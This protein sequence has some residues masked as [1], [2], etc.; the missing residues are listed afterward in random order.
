[1]T[2][3]PDKP[4]ISYE[5]MIEKLRSRNIEIRDEAFARSVLDSTSY[6][7]LIN[8]YK[9]PFSP[10]RQNDSFQPGTT[11][12]EI[13][14][15]HIIDMN[16]SSI[17]L[18]YILHTEFALKSRLSHLIA[19]RYGVISAMNHTFD[20]INRNPDDY[21]YRGHYSHSNPAR[22]NTL[23]H[24]SEVLQGVG[25]KMD[26][27]IYTIH[28][29]QSDSL[30]H[31]RENHNHV[32]PWVLTTSLTLGEVRRWYSILKPS[33]K[34]VIC[35]K[36]LPFEG[37]D[38]NLRKEYFAKSL[39]LIN[40]FR[41]G[42]AHGRAVCSTFCVTEVPKDMLIPVAPGLILESEYRNRVARSGIQALISVLYSLLPD[43]F[44]RTGL[45][46]DIISL[47]LPYDN[48]ELAGIRRQRVFINSKSVQEAFDLPENY[49]LRLF[50]LIQ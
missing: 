33:D 24:I 9:E 29:F 17:L 35:R 1:M 2:F 12:E 10:G 42:V 4:F 36:F 3:T 38:I 11:I 8:G 46:N 15:T 45:L 14:T 20:G 32:P 28:H 19:E 21:L 25:I 31:Y 22:N 37:Y 40:E 47:F 27:T 41:N 7:T 5:A 6:Y 26:G 48:P 23:R 30:Q 39:E 18:K 16:L 13:Y 49:I 43:G 44:L 50:N 34:V